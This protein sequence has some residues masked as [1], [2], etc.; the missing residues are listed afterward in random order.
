[1]AINQNAD[2]ND[3]STW[4]NENLLTTNSFVPHIDEIPNV[5]S[6]GIYF[7]FMH[8]NGYKALSNYVTIN[9]INPKYTKDFSVNMSVARGTS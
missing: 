7:W 1:M 2:F 9:P 5:K 4:L 8:P 3:L 6:K